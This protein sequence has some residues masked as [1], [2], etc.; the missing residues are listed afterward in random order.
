MIGMRNKRPPNL[1]VQSVQ[2]FQTHAFHWPLN[3]GVQQPLWQAGGPSG[4]AG[5]TAGA[6]MPWPYM[7]GT[8]QF[9]CGYPYGAASTLV[10]NRNA[11]NL[12]SGAVAFV[13]IGV[14]RQQTYTMET[15]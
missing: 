12:G 4:F 10:A 5:G 13:N 6:I 3:L 15:F 2:P 8:K 7:T 11:P 9:I 1:G 14:Y